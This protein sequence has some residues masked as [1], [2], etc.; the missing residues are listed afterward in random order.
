MIIQNP[1]RNTTLPTNH[2]RRNYV[3]PIA[4][5]TSI[6][7]NNLEILGPHAFNRTSIQDPL[8]VSYSRDPRYNFHDRLMRDIEHEERNAIAMDIIRNIEQTNQN[9]NTIRVYYMHD[10]PRNDRYF[11][12][13][14]DKLAESTIDITIDSLEVEY[15]KY[16]DIIRDLPDV[17][18]QFH[19]SVDG[20]MNSVNYR[21]IGVNGR[22][23]AV[24][25]RRLF[26]VDDLSHDEYN[27]F[28]IYHNDENVD[29]SHIKKQILSAIQKLKSEN[30]LYANL[31]DDKCV[32]L[33]ISQKDAALLV[34]S[35]QNCNRELLDEAIID[36]ENACPQ[37]KVSRII[38]S[39]SAIHP[40][41]HI[42]INPMQHA[43]ELASHYRNKNE[44][45]AVLIERLKSEEIPEKIIN[46]IAE[47][48]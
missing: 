12:Q 8:P 42:K 41:I 40:D 5:A 45:V 3:M 31:R 37:G 36:G 24:D 20:G 34:L 7:D 25:V 18:V 38:N 43:N 9:G 6:D 26:S 10:N 21:M 35:N 15:E 32:K 14:Y 17:V 1:Y 30:P 47:Y 23:I 27:G 2:I 46:L 44:P 13:F 19:H 39:L 4:Q 22:M 48:Y 16:I 28:Q 29:D 33:G 11:L